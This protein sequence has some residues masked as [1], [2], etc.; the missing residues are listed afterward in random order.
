MKRYK[1][2]F[3]TKRGRYRHWRI[4]VEAEFAAEAKVKAVRAWHDHPPIKEAYLFHVNAHKLK[5][6]EEFLYHWFKEDEHE[7][8]RNGVQLQDT[9]WR[10]QK[11][12]S[13]YGVS[14]LC[15]D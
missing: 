11:G 5:D 8:N 7:C 12:Q 3:V 4:D 9:A 1:V 6:T 10:V 14:A 13:C 15:S 2:E